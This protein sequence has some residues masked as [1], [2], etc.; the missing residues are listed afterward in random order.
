MAELR[1]YEPTWREKVHA[2]IQRGFEAL[3]MPRY[4]ANRKAYSIAGGGN[5]NLGI[6]LLDLTPAGLAFGAQEG[7]QSVERGMN[8][9]GVEGAIEGGFG[10]LEA[11]LSAVPAYKVTAP[12]VRKGANAVGDAAVRAITGR[13]N[14]TAMGAI[15]EISRLSPVPQMFD[16]RQAK[17]VMPQTAIVDPKTWPM[18][19]PQLMYHGTSKDIREFIPGKTGAIYASPDPSFAGTFTQHSK[20]RSLAELADQLDQDPDQKK[21]LLA[22]VVESAMS[23]DQLTNVNSPYH[24]KLASA[25]FVPDL[26]KYTKD[27]WVAE[28]MNRPLRDSLDTVGIRRELETFLADRLPTGPNVLPVYADAKNPFDYEKP[29]HINKILNRLAETDPDYYSAARRRALKADLSNGRW[30]TIE[31]T[32]VQDAM[33][34]LGYDGFFIKEHGVKN[35]GVYNPT[36]LKSAISDPAFEGLLE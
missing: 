28:F 21:Q 27:Y 4:Q 30:E 34:A 11:G 15:D 19:Y 29:A 1:A 9:G 33:K 25:G 36:Q 5:E 16:P 17:Q 31:G 8:M 14:A 18:R 6:G 32:D 20:N 24:Q 3:G 23:K 10:L 13:P 7:V 12:L 26:N 2:G 35:L 22:S